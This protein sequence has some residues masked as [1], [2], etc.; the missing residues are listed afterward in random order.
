MS[1]HVVLVD[2]HRGAARTHPENTLASFRAAL[3]ARA[4]SVEFDVHLSADGVPV[5]I[6]DDAVDRTTDGTGSV[7]SLT[8]AELR[9]LDAGSWKGARFAGERIPTLDEVLDLLVA[10]D[11][12][13][14]ELKTPSADLVDL[15][16]AGI[17]GRRL[18]HRVMVSSFH[19]DLLAASKRRLPGVWTHL[20]LDEPLPAGFWEGE[21]R[22]VNSLG[23]P[24]EH[25]TKA[26]VDE[27]RSRGRATWAWTVDDPDIAVR[28]AESGVA[29]VTTNDPV[30]MLA[31][32]A[33]AGYR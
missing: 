24:F 10:A 17:E 14:I 2:A 27:L 18:H 15:V 22:L 23:L 1:R 12:I 13:N 4:D 29:A 6:H 19:L 33:T 30:V 32:L 3:A 16:V 21:G 25:V 5:V 11:R 8:L 7:A 9:S 20:F 31:A 26:V 28:L